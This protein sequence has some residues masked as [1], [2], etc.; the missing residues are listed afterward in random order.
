MEI[1]PENHRTKWTINETKKLMDD[2]KKKTPIYL[3]AEKHKRTVG[4]IKFKLIRYAIELINK[5]KIEPKL[6]QITEITNLSK[7]DLL[8][9]FKKLKVII[10][11]DNKE[12]DLLIYTL[13]SINKNIRYIII[14]QFSLISLQ[15][16]NSFF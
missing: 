16:I 2:V 13:Y 11:D 9:G 1:L 5:K 12:E 14:L 10:D 4:A 7:D 8:D 3:I 6:N 15:F